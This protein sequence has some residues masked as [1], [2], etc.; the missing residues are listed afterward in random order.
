MVGGCC[1]L[2][3]GVEFASDFQQ[4]LGEARQEVW[5]R[6]AGQGE[7]LDH[8]VPHAVGMPQGFGQRDAIVLG[9]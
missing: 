9:G 5:R 2:G 4:S 3:R 8:G 7:A 6:D 1:F